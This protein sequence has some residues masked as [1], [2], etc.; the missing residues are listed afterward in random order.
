MNL[1]EHISIMVLLFL[2]QILMISEVN[3]LRLLFGLVKRESAQRLS[4]SLSVSVLAII[5]FRLSDR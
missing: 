3:Y 1:S 5:H 4:V 2:N